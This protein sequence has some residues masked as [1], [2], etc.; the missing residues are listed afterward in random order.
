[1]QASLFLTPL[2]DFS[3]WV[4]SDRWSAIEWEHNNSN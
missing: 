1:M 4:P 3:E 2:T